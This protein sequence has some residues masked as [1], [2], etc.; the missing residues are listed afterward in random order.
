MSTRCA[1]RA[2]M[3]WF[4]ILGLTNVLRMVT[5]G[6]GETVRPH[7]VDVVAPGVALAL[8][9]GLFQVTVLKRG[10][11]APAAIDSFFRTASTRL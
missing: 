6:D 11:R 4:E 9:S 3:T 8:R 7:F 5:V 10:T 1:D 2:P